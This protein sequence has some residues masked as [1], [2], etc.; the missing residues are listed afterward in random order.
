MTAPLLASQKIQSQA[1]EPAAPV[2]TLAS[3]KQRGNAVKK[4]ASLAGQKMPSLASLKRGKQGVQVKATPGDGQK[5]RTVKVSGLTFRVRLSDQ[6][7]RVMLMMVEAGR[8]R[9]PYLVSLRRS[10]WASVEN[11]KVAF[12]AKVK[13]KL[14]QRI[15]KA[16]DEEID[17]LQCL[18]A[19]IAAT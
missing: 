15:E 8:Q 12:M 14:S 1:V 4:A 18:L 9:E 7:Y 3:Q 16:S 11:D 2:E 13:E 10:E 17:R 5:S 19:T 6:G